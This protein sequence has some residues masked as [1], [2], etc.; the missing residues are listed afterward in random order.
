M[1]ALMMRALLFL[2]SALLASAAAVAQVPTPSPVT[3]PA[4]ETVLVPAVPTRGPT[5]TPS[6]WDLPVVQRP[7]A[8][9]EHEGEGGENLAPVTFDPLT[10]DQYDT[11]LDSL[12]SRTPLKFPPHKA[13][14]KVDS[15]TAGVWAGS[16]EKVESIGSKIVLRFR[17]KTAEL[18]SPSM[19]GGVA[20]DQLLESWD[21]FLD[22]KE[23]WLFIK[24]GSPARAQDIDGLRAKV[25]TTKFGTRTPFIRGARDANLYMAIPPYEDYTTTWGLLV[26][27]R[28]LV[29][30]SASELGV[31]EYVLGPS[32]YELSEA[33]FDFQMRGDGLMSTAGQE[34]RTAMWLQTSSNLPRGAYNFDESV[35]S[36]PKVSVYYKPR[37]AVDFFRFAPYDE[38]QEG[39]LLT[40]QMH[41]RA[42]YLR[43]HMFAHVFHVKKMIEPSP[44]KVV[45]EGKKVVRDEGECYVV[46]MNKYSWMEYAKKVATF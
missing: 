35:S 45:A 40:S 9:V 39:A 33:S 18:V 6:E 26:C 5:P 17:R 22:L 13:S 19:T 11:F 12:R 7:T 24:H 15:A 8:S 25:D 38:I 21:L 31:P 36:M 16:K 23:G 46:L 4:A 29:R 44:V 34:G 41:N 43:R 28:R 10:Q 3:S 30:E 2:F 20:G 1:S 27:P 42:G 32:P 37:E 14:Q